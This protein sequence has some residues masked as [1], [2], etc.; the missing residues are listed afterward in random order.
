MRK[1]GLEWSIL[2]TKGFGVMS[3]MRTC[4]SIYN[5]IQIDWEYTLLFAIESKLIVEE[6]I[7]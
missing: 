1:K 3:D 5:W 2:S 6:R 4:S 7:T